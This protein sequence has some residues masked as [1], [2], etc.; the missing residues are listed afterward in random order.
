[1]KKNGH[2]W[3]DV[4]V[5]PYRPGAGV[6][7]GVEVMDLPGL[8]E[9]AR[10]HE[11][12]LHAPRRLGFHELV[13]VRAGAVRCSVDFDE[14]EVGAG[15]WLWVRP[16]QVSQYR[17]DLAAGAEATVVLF[18][19]G[20]LSG[21]SVAATGVD[22]RVHEL[23]LTPTGSRKEAVDGVLRLLE[24][25]YE[26]LADL[27][28]EVHID[29]MRHLLAVLLLRLAHLQGERDDAGSEAFRRFQQAVDRDFARSH[30]VADYAARLGYSVR[31][32]TRATRA[33]AGSGA[34]RFIDDRVLLEAKR[35]LVHT[36]LPPAAIGDRIG[37]PH[38][39]A[40]SAF[41]RHRTGMTPTTFRTIARGTAGER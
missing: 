16:G 19:S 36:G 6:P 24:S 40:F 41:F 25:E 38:A 29:V 35:L 13:A 32:L 2:M 3:A 9:R 30:R 21:T 34:K 17:G 4:R 28:L 33:F 5:V 31:T 27:P 12:D 23:P 20:F 10:G 14:H 26:H 18:P 1:M 22:R 7:P 8:V 11:V 15:S 39:T 37:F